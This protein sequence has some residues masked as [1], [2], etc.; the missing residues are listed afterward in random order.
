MEATFKTWRTSRKL[1]FDLLENH[2]LDQLNK[3]PKGFNNNIV[4]NV[5]HIILAQQ[6]LVYKGAGMQLQVPADM[7]GKYGIGTKPDEPVTAGELEEL[8]SL[9]IDIAVQT[10]SDYYQGKFVSYQ[11]RTTSSGF[12]L[13]SV[14]D[15]IVFNNLHEGLHMGYINSIRKFV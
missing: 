9:L 4:W 12:H 10:E 2:N 5:G 6:G 15:A 11:E 1:Y 14:E 8:K 13:G 7:V 3:V